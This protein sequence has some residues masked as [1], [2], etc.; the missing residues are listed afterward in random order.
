MW[1]A[2]RDRPLPGPGTPMA[3]YLLLIVIG[4][5]VYLAADE[6][7]L[8]EFWTPIEAL[9]RGRDKVETTGDRLFNLMRLAVLVAVPL[10]AGWAGDSCTAPSTA[11]PTSPPPPHPTI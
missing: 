10:G 5:L 9:L 7:R 6:A 1:L 11:P 3:M 4:V 8:K 2:G